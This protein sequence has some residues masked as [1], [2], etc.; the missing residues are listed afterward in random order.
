LWTNP[1]D[2]VFSPFTGIGSE[3]YVALRMG[4]RFIGSELK[5]SYFKIASENL[6]QVNPDGYLFPEFQESIGDW[7]RGGSKP[8][9]EFASPTIPD[10]S[11]LDWVTELS[12][13]MAH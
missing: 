2:L 12:G 1:G 11:Q 6:K 3:G 13:A 10:G 7:K 4:R 5:P 9:S 8:Y